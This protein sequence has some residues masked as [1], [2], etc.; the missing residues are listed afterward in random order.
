VLL[1]VLLGSVLLVLTFFGWA[2]YRTGQYDGRERALEA[3][4]HRAYS[5]CIDAGEQ[6]GICAKQVRTVCGQD[7]FWS[8][9]RPFAF[10]PGS[11]VD[12]QQSR[13]SATVGS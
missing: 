9:D 11:V 12:D 3:R 5:A 13:C 7:A 8:I 10:L 4:Y 6:P 2:R 1:G